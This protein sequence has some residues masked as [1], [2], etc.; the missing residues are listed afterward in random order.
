MV[1]GSDSHVSG[2]HADDARGFA[3]S[4]KAMVESQLRPSGV[5][6]PRVIAAMASVPRERFVPAERRGSAYADRPIPLG[7][8]RALNAPVITGR[9]LTEL[10]LRPSDR[11]LLVGAATGYA[12]AL[13]THLLA[14]LVALEEEEALIAIARVELEGSG[15]VL[16][17]GPLADGH[18]AGAP[19]DVI[20]IDGAVDRVPDA[21]IAQL[22]DGGRLATGLLDGGVG[23]LVVGR[24]AGTGFGVHAF[25]DADPVR[26]PGFAAALDFVF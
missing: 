12:A 9:L 25:E 22:E 26:L 19:Y 4:R 20:M 18:A 13:L 10:R 23:R 6:D 1:A 8:A 21:L 16:V 24:R 15:V 11:A 14:D 2:T 3:L 5:N 7:G 17:Q